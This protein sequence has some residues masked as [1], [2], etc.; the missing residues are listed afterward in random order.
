MPEKPMCLLYEGVFYEMAVT[1]K[2]VKKNNLYV[3]YILANTFKQRIKHPPGH[4]PCED[5]LSFDR[6]KS[7][8]RI[9]AVF[10]C[11]LG[12]GS[13]FIRLYRKVKRGMLNVKTGNYNPVRKGRN[14]DGSYGGGV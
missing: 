13:Q 11:A 9:S 7:D 2:I 5:N 10:F 3:C 12:D 6:R 14:Q 8:Q 1:Q 4:T